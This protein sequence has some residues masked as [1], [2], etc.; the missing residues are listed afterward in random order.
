MMHFQN[1]I[2]K[3]LNPEIINCISGYISHGSVQFVMISNDAA[4]A[5]L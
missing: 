1:M 5:N 4:I 2:L 3:N